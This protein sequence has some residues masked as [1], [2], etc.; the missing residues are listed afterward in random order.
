MYMLCSIHQKAELIIK[1]IQACLLY[2][3]LCLHV[4][5]CQVV[6]PEYG[7]QMCYPFLV[8][9]AVISECISLNVCFITLTCITSLKSLGPD[10]GSARVF[11]LWFKPNLD[12]WEKGRVAPVLIGKQT[13]AHESFAWLFPGFTGK[14]G[15]NTRRSHSPHPNLSFF[16]PFSFQ[17]DENRLFLDAAARRGAVMLPAS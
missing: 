12:K 10:P 14:K 2:E 7:N 17:W 15:L 5:L 1:Q 13:D 3:T 6:L 8:F 9:L 4:I 11:F 16:K